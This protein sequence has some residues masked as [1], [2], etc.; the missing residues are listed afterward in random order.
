MI[1]LDKLPPQAIDAEETLIG[2][3]LVYPDV[4]HE[5]KLKPEMF[6]MDSHRVIFEAM[7]DLSV[8]G[9][10]DLVTVTNRLRDTNKLT[11]AGGVVTITQLTTNIFTDQMINKHAL[12]IKEKY[13]LR[14][15]IRIAFGIQD[16]AYSQ[17]L[18]ET[19]EFAEDSL[20]KLSDFTQV[21]E[22][23][24]VSRCVDD[25]LAEIE[26]V[27]TKEKSLVG[28]PS[29]FT[30]IDR[31]T[32]GWQPGNLIII[33]GRPSMGK[34]ALAL[35]LALNP[36]RLKYPVCIFSLEMSREELTTRLLSSVTKYTN[37]EIRNANINFEQLVDKS[38]EIA[39]LPLIIDDTAELKLSELRSKVMK[40]II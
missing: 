23:E 2:T 28:V 16:K 4:I 36:A 13:L 22:P 31:I 5:I 14:E 17:D 26:K 10:F 15:Y 18:G 40:M 32:G 7:L 25:L 8:R 3:C 27:F 29:G 9:S 19:V 38:N 21:K 1:R 37:V 34:T 20:F 39:N 30:K 24:H 35:Q 12:I 6:Y 33:A 11:L